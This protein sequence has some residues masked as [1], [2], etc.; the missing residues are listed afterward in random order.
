MYWYG[1][2]E[3][4]QQQVS[5][6][7][8]WHIESQLYHFRTELPSVLWRLARNRRRQRLTQRQHWPHVRIC[9]LQAHIDRVDKFR[10][11]LSLPK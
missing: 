1:G 5:P 3:E 10:I 4:G 7:G 9:G 2:E 6:S 8:R 11:S